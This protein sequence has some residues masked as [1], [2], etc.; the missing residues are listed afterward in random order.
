MSS[1]S[2]IAIQERSSL[3]SPLLTNESEHT[4]ISEMCDDDTWHR[5]LPFPYVFIRRCLQSSVITKSLLGIYALIVIST[6]ASICV[7]LMAHTDAH[8]SD[9]TIA[10]LLYD[11][12]QTILVIVLPFYAAIFLRSTFSAP[13][14]LPVLRLALLNDPYLVLKYR[15]IAYVNA[16]LVVLSIVSFSIAIPLSNFEIILYVVFSPFYIMPFCYMYT[17]ALFILEA[18]RQ[19]TMAFY[20]S[21][22]AEIAGKSACSMSDL[23]RQY[24]SLHAACRSTS[25]LRGKHIF[26][27]FVIALLFVLY[28]IWN[29]YQHDLAVAAMLAYVVGGLVTLIELGCVLASTNEAGNIVN[30]ELSTL[31]MYQDCE[32]GDKNISEA[33]HLLQCATN[34]KLEIPFFGNF[35]LR[36]QTLLAVV[37]SALGAIIPGFVLHL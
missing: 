32:A 16:L 35:V 19:C 15:V 24:I 8:P 4:S 27:L 5:V 33:I 7:Y 30:R 26:A 36:P 17:I 14:I 9:A 28:S 34:S 2:T 22:C 3:A 20:A 18:H 13:D 12:F 25:R 31:L 10:G 21:L 29:L 1:D 11:I 37:G 23:K 6:I